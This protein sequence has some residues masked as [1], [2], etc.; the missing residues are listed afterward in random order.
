MEVGWRFED[1]TFYIILVVICPAQVL[2]AGGILMVTM[3]GTLGAF[4]S[5]YQSIAVATRPK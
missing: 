1:R 3:S 2:V 5:R 4:A